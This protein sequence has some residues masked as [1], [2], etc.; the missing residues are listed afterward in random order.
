MEQD[1][2]DNVDVTNSNDTKYN[3]LD[4]SMKIDFSRKNITAYIL[5]WLFIGILL[6]TTFTYF[7]G[8]RIVTI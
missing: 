8:G 5:T 2:E 6:L 3:F 4:V 7:F 1:K